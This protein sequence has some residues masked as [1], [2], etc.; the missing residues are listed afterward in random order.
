M[1]LASEQAV[2]SRKT[3]DLFAEKGAAAPSD[4]QLLNQLEQIPSDTEPQ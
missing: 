1:I 3:F 4:Q 2:A